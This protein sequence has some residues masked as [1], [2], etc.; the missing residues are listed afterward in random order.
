VFE[1]HTKFQ[2]KERTRK[3]T[4]YLEIGKDEK[5]ENTENVKAVVRRCRLGNIGD[6]RSS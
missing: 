3:T 1:W 6:K 4:N 2:K 5:C